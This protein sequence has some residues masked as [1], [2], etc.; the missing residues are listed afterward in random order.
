MGSA[1]VTRHVTVKARGYTLKAAHQRQN[2]GDILD[3]IA[4]TD[5]ALNK[6]YDTSK[7]QESKR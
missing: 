2:C 6:N 5:M 7:L 4:S 1:K 3:F